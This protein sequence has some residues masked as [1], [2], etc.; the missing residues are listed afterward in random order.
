[1]GQRSFLKPFVASVAGVLASSC[2]HAAAPLPSHLATSVSEAR[3]TAEIGS[4]LEQS[5]DQ[6]AVS[7]HASHS[8][9]SSHASHSSH[10]SHSSSSY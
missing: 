2:G 8:S 7:A 10:S 1:M 5:S 4:T 3:P 9:H 6:G